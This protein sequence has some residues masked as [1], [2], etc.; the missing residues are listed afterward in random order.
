[1]GG[2]GIQVGGLKMC[3]EYHSMAF[4]DNLYVLGRVA[5]VDYHLLS[6]QWG[7]FSS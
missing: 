1:M 4:G 6:E 7:E 3:S 5:Y 2:R